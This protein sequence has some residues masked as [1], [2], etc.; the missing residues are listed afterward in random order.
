MGLEVATEVSNSILEVQEEASTAQ[1]S[2]KGLAKDL[3]ANLDKVS[4]AATLSRKS[5]KTS[6]KEQTCLN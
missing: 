2:A 4:R 1:A 5:T 6:S 3:A